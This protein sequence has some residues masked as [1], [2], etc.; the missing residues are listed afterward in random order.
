MK[1]R[2]LF[3][4]LL[5]QLLLL[6][7]LPACSPA[8]NSNSGRLAEGARQGTYYEIL[9]RSF[10]DSDGDG[11]GDFRGLAAKMDYLVD[12]GITGIWLMPCFDSP[13]YHGY[14]TSDYYN[15][16]PDYGTMEDF[17]AFIAEADKH[18]ISVILDL[19]VNHSSSQHPWFQASRDPNS[20]YRDWY[21]WTEDGEGVNLRATA[22]GGNK[23]WNETETGHYAGLFWG[24]MPDLNLTNPDVREEVKNIAAFWLDKGVAGF[25]LDAVPHIFDAAKTPSND[26]SF[27]ERNVEWWAEFSDFCRSVNPDCFLVGEVW[28]SPVARTEYVTAIDSVFHFD[29]GETLAR[30]IVAGVNNGNAFVKNMKIE[31]DRLA[32]VNPD[33]INSIFLSNH[34]QTRIITAVR[35]DIDNMKMAASVY[36]TMQGLPFIYY[37]EELGML[38]G[39][40]DE[41][42][43][44]PFMWGEDDPYLTTWR[45]SPHNKN[46]IPYDEQIA[47]PDSLLSHY[48]RVIRLRAATPALFAGV[49]EPV[50][51]ENG[52]IM[53]YQMITPEQTV[54]VLHNISAEEQTVD[55]NG[56][57]KVLF[58]T[59]KEGFSAKKDGI[60][61]PAKCSVVIEVE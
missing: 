14:D 29:M 50:E 15:I 53:S 25:R 12:L 38:G 19:V 8:A 4:L 60:V 33:A 40:P 24:E 3:A 41:N 57:G 52:A 39:K 23:V 18:G 45:E 28:T 55:L 37:G 22:F 36:L 59:T 13:S 5:A 9:V 61:L 30:S 42:I 20:P 56:E 54:L 27:A 21:Y 32:E 43:R 58:V 46:T 35:N 1:S 17:E 2:K 10:A 48:Q 7:L 26:Q 51:Q 11:I 31:Y 47:D 34:D 6:L 49:L 16:N 44:T